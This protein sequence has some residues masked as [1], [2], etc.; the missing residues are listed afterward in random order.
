MIFI[1]FI[2]FIVAF[3]FLYEA[4]RD[5]WSEVSKFR[6]NPLIIFKKLVLEI[7]YSILRLLIRFLIFLIVNGIVFLVLILGLKIFGKNFNELS[8][9]SRENFIALSFLISIIVNILVGEPLKIIF[10]DDE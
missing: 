5:W 7:L 2:F 10:L 1:G 6:S 3:G 4:G 8:Y 9:S